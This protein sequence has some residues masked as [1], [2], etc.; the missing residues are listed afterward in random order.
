MSFLRLNE[1][2]GK[3]LLITYTQLRRS[4]IFNSLWEVGAA[5][6]DVGAP[7]TPLDLVWVPVSEIGRYPVGSLIGARPGKVVG[8]KRRLSLTGLTY[9]GL[10]EPLQEEDVGYELD[11]FQPREHRTFSW[12]KSTCYLR[13]VSG[14]TSVLIDAQELF[15]FYCGSLGHLTPALLDAVHAPG[16]PLDQII[17]PR[18]TGWD[19]DQLVIAPRRSFCGTAA[20]LELA[21]ILSDEAL[22]T[23]TRTALHDYRR[24]SA[25]GDSAVVAMQ[26][27]GPLD[28]V[29]EV[30]AAD[31]RS[32]SGRVRRELVVRRIVSDL[33]A[34]RFGEL[35][36]RYPFAAFGNS[37]VS[38]D[39]DPTEPPDG[40]DGTVDLDTRMT[41]GKLPS[42]RAFRVGSVT[43]RFSSQFPGWRGARVRYDYAEPRDGK[44]SGG[45]GA[46]G[47]R[48]GGTAASE[49]SDLPGTRSGALLRIV[50]VP[51]V[52]DEFVNTT[53][54]PREPTDFI[55]SEVVERLQPQIV[56]TAGLPLRMRT[57]L[58]AGVELMNWQAV[59]FSPNVP[60]AGGEAALLVLPPS[61]G[62]IARLTSDGRFRR[63]VALPLVFDNGLVWAVEIERRSAEEQFAIG[64]LAAQRD[65]A[66]EVDLLNAV[67]CQVCRRSA[68]VRGAD[69]RGTWPDAEFLDVRL[70]SVIHSRARAHYVNLAG[71][72]LERSRYLLRPSTEA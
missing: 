25:A 48:K 28:L 56:S 19:G 16:N 64:L 68:Q 70:A 33:R 26:P 65:V 20:V 30:E 63:I 38:E 41:K 11:L 50:Q 6:V 7:D 49:V 66:D 23:V 72:I 35:I 39:P 9:S 69:P 40:Q 3:Y 8:K 53:P 57:F 54:R 67:M 5:V 32:D 52:N 36:V 1:L 71:A 17:N 31:L 45:S 29:V 61:W 51:S 24:L 21:L 22:N 14:R 37:E 12:P 4:P 43:G 44:G 10:S 62:G 46:G 58:R 2:P 15:R 55:S 13:Y 34:P 47:P 18:E 42:L 60:G 27:K 59:E